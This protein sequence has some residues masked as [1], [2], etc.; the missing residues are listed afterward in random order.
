MEDNEKKL[1][2]LSNIAGILNR[3]H[4]TW[5]IGGSMLLYFKNKTDVFHD[6][7]IMA[8]EKDVEKL[9][10]LLLPLGVLAPST[11][12]KHYKTKC[13]LEFTIDDVE[14]DVMAGFAIV[15]DEKEYDCSLRLDEIVEY[16]CVNGENIP[17][18]SLDTWRRYYE[19]MG[20]TSKVEMIDK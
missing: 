18:Q 1:N 2:V 13:F 14:V 7:D 6:I 20:R 9:K 17:L 5:A 10:S 16:I 12:N 3:N 11:P 15:C 19:L 8:L 4:I